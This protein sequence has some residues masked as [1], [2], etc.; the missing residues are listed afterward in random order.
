MPVESSAREAAAELRRPGP[1]Q[2]PL[3]KPLKRYVRSVA[4]E[5]AAVLTVRVFL[6]RSM[7]P[8]PEM[9]MPLAVWSA[10]RTIAPPVELMLVGPLTLTLTL[11]SP[12]AAEMVA[13]AVCVWAPERLRVPGPVLLR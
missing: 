12:A 10:L 9:A 8:P 6:I 5:V 11:V 2:A 3:A 13:V 7:D 1:F 4:A